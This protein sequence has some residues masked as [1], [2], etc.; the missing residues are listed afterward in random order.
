MKAIL[1]YANDDAGL[2]SRL[3]AA[4]EL[5]RIFDGHLTCL[6]ITPYDAFI[7]GDPFGGFYTLPSVVEG[8]AEGEAVHRAKV[9]NRLKDSGISWDW[10]S[11]VGQAARVLVDRS[12]LADLVIVSTSVARDRLAGPLTLASDVALHV[13]SS[14]LAVPC[15]INESVS[16]ETAVI[17]WN[18][19]AE[20]GQ[21]IRLALPILRQVKS[22]HIV[23]VKEADILFPA[24]TA[25]QYLALYGI[26]S[27]LHERGHADSDVADVILEV[28]RE[29]G[30]N[31]IVMGAYG[32][33]RLR[34]AVLGGVTRDL[35]GRSEIPLMLAH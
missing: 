17:A 1:L 32:H 7:V 12:R 35:L 26:P 22:V 20:V 16:F 15:E 11:Y 30:G 27:K 13:R 9:Q 4:I 19:S 3:Q 14:V 29:I 2:E 28:A 24:A 33:S 18:G 21:A 6:L 25:G 10:V 31:F 5:T 34:E 8:L 23:N